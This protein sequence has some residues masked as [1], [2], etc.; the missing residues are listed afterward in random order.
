MKPLRIA[1]TLIIAAL[2]LVG[3]ARAYAAIRDEVRAY[4]GVYQAVTEM[5]AEQAAVLQYLGEAVGTRTGADGKPAPVSRADVLA[6]VAA[7]VIKQ[8]AAAQAQAPAKQ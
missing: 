7:N 4:K 6:A 5:K 8:A 2:A 1:L 3:G